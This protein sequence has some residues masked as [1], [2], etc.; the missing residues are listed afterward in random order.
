VTFSRSLRLAVAVGLTAFVLWQADAASVWRATVHANWSWIA[1]AVALVLV[2]RALN[3]WRWID[4]FQEESQWNLIPRQGT[5]RLYNFGELHGIRGLKP[6]R[7]VELLPHVLTQVESLPE[8]EGDPF[9]GPNG[10]GAVGLDAKI[11][12]SSNVTMDA[13]VN[14]DF[15]Q[16]EADPSVVN[17]TT[18]ETFYDEKRP[19]FLE[20]KRIFTQTCAVCHGRHSTEAICHLYA[21][22]V[23]EAVQWATGKEFRIIETHCLAKG[24]EYC[25]FE[26]GEARE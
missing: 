13:T 22:S 8:Q 12:L 25:R 2:D 20:G 17:L 7:R 4:R 14:P 3:A 9:V 19:F 21:G 16:V 23:G 5:G 24:D 10:T 26:I 15:G 11:G 6:R 1:A 18:Y